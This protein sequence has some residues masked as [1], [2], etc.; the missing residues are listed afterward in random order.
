MPKKTYKKEQ[1]DM[2][3]DIYVKKRMKENAKQEERKLQLKMAARQ[4]EESRRAT[5]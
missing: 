3:A 4:V 2:I 1:G 5:S